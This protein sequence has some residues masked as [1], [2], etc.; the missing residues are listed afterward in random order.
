MQ[1]SFGDP[2]HPSGLLYF[3]SFVVFLPVD[4][5]LIYSFKKTFFEKV[6]RRHEGIIFAQKTLRSTKYDTTVHSKDCV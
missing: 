4:W 1:Y 3:H 5:V 2:L 6:K